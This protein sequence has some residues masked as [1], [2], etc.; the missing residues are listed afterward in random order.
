MNTN[1][2]HITRDKTIRIDNLKHNLLKKQQTFPRDTQHRQSD[3]ELIYIWTISVLLK[4]VAVELIGD[5]S[6]RR[7][8]NDTLE[9]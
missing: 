8:G 1:S 2:H 5:V 6:K 4:A 7:K 3:Y 9:M